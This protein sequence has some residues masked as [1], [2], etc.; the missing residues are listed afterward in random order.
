MRVVLTFLFAFIIL[1]NL[2]AQRFVLENFSGGFPTGWNPD[3]ARINVVSSS[4]S[5]GY[6]SPVPASGGNNIIFTNCLPN[7]STITLTTSS[8]DFTGKSGIRIGFGIRRTNTGIELSVS[9]SINGGSPV[10]IATTSGTGTTWQYLQYDI[11][12]LDNQNNVVFLFQIT[13]G[14]A[15]G[16]AACGMGSGNTRIDDFAIGQNMSLGLP[17]PVTF[18][19][20]ELTKSLNNAMISFSTA[21]ETNNSHFNI[22]RSGDGRK[23][24]SIG[25]IKGAG[26]SREERHYYFT[27]EKPLPGTNYYRIRQTDY[28]GTYSF[29]EIKAV[30][31]ALAPAFD[32]NPKQTEGRLW[33]DTDIE[34]Y[35][36]QIFGSDGRVMY[37]SQKLSSAQSIDL[38]H[39]KPGI[40][41]LKL[42]HQ[43][44]SHTQ[45]II[46]I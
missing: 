39:L 32:I 7:A 11:P 30:R 17:M 42:T 45:R 15:S 9:Y 3:D 27:D 41:Y 19:S 2:P 14:G 4:A 23:F 37:S 6:S 20:F 8:Y 18:N 24:H 21:S 26:D 1:L 31:F 29:S 28:D 44:V 40:Y 5:S 13:T 22:E 33:I 16:M 25:E 35:D 43:G 46:R 10:S 34:N 12:A 36:L 38:N